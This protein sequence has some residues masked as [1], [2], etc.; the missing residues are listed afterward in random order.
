MNGF[1]N[2]CHHARLDKSSQGIQFSKRLL[3]PPNREQ[4][5]PYNN[6][7]HTTLDDDYITKPKRQCTGVMPLSSYSP[8]FPTLLNYTTGS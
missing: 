6:H 4:P 5:G 1:E 3:K 8:Q 2:R 7:K